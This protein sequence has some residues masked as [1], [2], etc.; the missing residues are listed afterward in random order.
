MVGF[1]LE[2]K[3]EKDERDFNFKVNLYFRIAGLK[4]VPARPPAMKLIK[5]ALQPSHFSSRL[6]IS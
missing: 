4:V 2:S 1:Q 6:S 3:Q 5:G